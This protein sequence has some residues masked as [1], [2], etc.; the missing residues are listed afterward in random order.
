MTVR[1]TLEKYIIAIC[2]VIAAFLTISCQCTDTL[3]SCKKYIFYIL[4]GLP[5]VYV[6]IMNIIPT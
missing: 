1:R 3:L 4:V 2:L 6:F 5:L